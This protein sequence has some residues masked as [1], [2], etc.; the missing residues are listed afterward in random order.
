MY[1]LCAV[2]AQLNSIFIFAYGFL[3]DAAQLFT[4]LIALTTQSRYSIINDIFDVIT[5]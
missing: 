3:C 2:T 1:Y 4:S 5:I